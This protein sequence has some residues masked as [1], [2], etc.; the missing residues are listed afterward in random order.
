MSLLCVTVKR[1]ALV[2]TPSQFNTYVTLKL[3]NVKSTTASMKGNEPEWEID[4]I[5]E[6]NRMDIG[7]IIEVWNKGMLWDKL[8]GLQWLP[9][10]RIKYTNESGEG[11]WLSLDQELVMENGEVVGTK[12]PTGHS[13]L[14]EAHFELPCDIEDLE[15][16]EL[17][18]KLDYLN[19]ILG[20][21]ISSLREQDRRHNFSLNSGIS[22]DSD[23]TSDVSYPTVQHPS[24]SVHHPNSSASQFGGAAEITRRASEYPSSRNGDRAKYIEPGNSYET[25]YDNLPYNSRDRNDYLDRNSISEDPLYYN[26]RPNR[27]MNSHS[28]DRSRS[29]RSTSGY[30]NSLSL[31]YE[32]DMRY[33]FETDRSSRHCHWDEDTIDNET[34]KKNLERFQRSDRRRSLERQTGF[35]ESVHDRFVEHYNPEEYGYRDSTETYPQSSFESYPSFREDSVSTDWEKGSRYTPL[36]SFSEQ[37]SYYMSQWDG[38]PEPP[39]PTTGKIAGKYI[40]D[41][42]R[43]DWSKVNGTVGGRGSRHAPE[44]EEWRNDSTSSDWKKRSL[45]SEWSKDSADWRKESPPPDW[46]QETPPP[47]IK[48][49]KQVRKGW[50]DDTPPVPERVS[51]EAVKPV[52]RWGTHPVEPVKGND[53]WNGHPAKSS[54]DIDQWNGHPAKSSKDIDQWNGLPAKPVKDV[55]QWNGHSMKPTKDI[56]Q[57][58]GHSMKPTK[59]IDQ[60]NGHSA[61]PAKDSADRWNSHPV[62]PAKEPDR[63]NNHPPQPT[64]DFDRWNEEPAEIPLQS[65]DRWSNKGLEP[66]KTAERRNSHSVVPTIK[67][68]EKWNG[69]TAEVK[70]EDRWN[71]HSVKSKNGDRWKAGPEPVKNEERWDSNGTTEPVRNAERWKSHADSTKNGWSEETI[72][73]EDWADEEMTDHQM[74]A[75]ISEWQDD[76][77]RNEWLPNEEEYEKD[78]PKPEYPEIQVKEPPEIKEELESD[79]N[80]KPPPSPREPIEFETSLTLTVDLSEVDRTRDRRPSVMSTKGPIDVP[81]LDLSGSM[82]AVAAQQEVPQLPLDEDDPTMSRAK[83]R[84]INAFNKIVAQ[85]NEVSFILDSSVEKQWAQFMWCRQVTDAISLKSKVT[86]VSDSL[87]TYFDP[88]EELA[89]LKMFFCMDY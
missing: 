26:S 44:P 27:R 40:P 80:F 4:F 18:K 3:Q 50:V 56:D 81:L 64:K 76:N 62:E 13:L 31:D 33:S 68:N 43:T 9:L 75:I 58:N 78:L 25:D 48:V 77:E 73:Q 35:D 67:S 11:Q 82:M 45:E 7:L 79:I 54:K 34:D 12:V 41:E 46:N 2:G 6:T 88:L 42:P 37:D 52:D 14:L 70:N 38:E 22:E 71:E 47:V 24:A 72:V 8:L 10:T 87:L 21:E 39:P 15:D 83:K 28:T 65:S 69:H 61:K 19:V 30:D 59:D 1:A 63:W 66:A 32:S 5:F 16:E 17:M 85:L 20:N 55:D 49:P 29:T 89:Y 36:P 84:W 86:S 23:Y 57:W 53:Q 51:P 74:D 60:W